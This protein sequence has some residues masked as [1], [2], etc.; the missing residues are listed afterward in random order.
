[1]ELRKS[2]YLLKE[3]GKRTLSLCNWIAGIGGDECWSGGK[4]EQYIYIYEQGK[5]KKGWVSLCVLTCGG[6]KSLG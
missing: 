1:M 2:G 3:V 4:N 6:S 5:K